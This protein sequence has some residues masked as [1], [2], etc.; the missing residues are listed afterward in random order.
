NGRCI[1]T[2]SLCDGGNTCGDFS[3][4]QNCNRS[5]FTFPPG[6]GTSVLNT[7]DS[8]S[9]SGI[10]VLNFTTSSE[11][12]SA[13]T[14]RIWLLHLGGKSTKSEVT[15]ELDLP[16][17]EELPSS[18]F[19]PRIADIPY[20]QVRNSSDAQSTEVDRGW[21]RTAQIMPS[22]DEYIK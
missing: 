3:D 7:S 13:R 12:T 20:S 10:P 21:K 14:D 2:S 11:F 15:T 16:S 9:W 4:E 17:S 22:F 5:L 19:A 8:G 6:E 18:R 1:P